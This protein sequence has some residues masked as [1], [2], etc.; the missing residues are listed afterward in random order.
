MLALG[1]QVEIVN[2]HCHDKELKT[3]LK[4]GVKQSLKSEHFE[5]KI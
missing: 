1:G 5:K 2:N 4:C 3:L